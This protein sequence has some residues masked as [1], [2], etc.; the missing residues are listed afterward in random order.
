M[1]A[2]SLAPL[3]GC[4]IGTLTTAALLRFKRRQ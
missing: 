3:F 2:G 1:L 4:L